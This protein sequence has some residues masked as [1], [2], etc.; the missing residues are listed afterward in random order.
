MRR[1]DVTIAVAMA[2]YA[3]VQVIVLDEVGGPVL[4]SAPCLVAAAL[5]LAWR[6]R[7]PFASAA[8]VA[9]A[10]ALQAATGQAPEGL[11]VSAPLLIS[12][13]SIAAHGRGRALVAGLALQLLAVAAHT[14]GDPEIRT[15]EDV[16]DA[17][18]WWLALVAGWLVGHAV[19]RRRQARE[20][21]EMARDL[22]RERDEAAG[23]ERTRMARELHDVV[24]HGVS[25]IALQAGAAQET[26]DGD[27]D[28]TRARLAAIEQTARDSA[29]ELRR[30]LG[31]LREDGDSD[32]H[33]RRPL[34]GLNDLPPLVEGLRAAGLPVT[35]SVEGS[36]SHMPAGV[37]LSAYRVVQEG[38]TNAVKH[39]RPSCVDIVVRHDAGALEVCVVDDGMGARADA[40]R[41]GYGLAGLRERVAVHGGTLESGPREVGGFALRAHLPAEGS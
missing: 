11:V 16:G 38:L 10:V 31:V 40:S 5:A 33:T 34:P 20:L 36:A 2:A 22:E 14:A 15:A 21:G 18:F 25:V 1:L 6:T 9:V 4:I 12:A 29:S 17:S 27:P 8:A 35:L 39:A 24:A 32:S 13:Y 28:R 3:A 7:A 41:L 19:H 23:R 30:M 37:Q 26:L